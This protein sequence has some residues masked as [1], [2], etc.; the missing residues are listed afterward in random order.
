MSILSQRN[1]SFFDLLSSAQRLDP[2]GHAAIGLA[3]VLWA[4]TAV[5]QFAS[6]PN[7]RDLTARRRMA[8]RYDEARYV[9]PDVLQNHKKNVRTKQE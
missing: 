1:R 4:F 9:T 7:C 3:R 8:A 6:G 2:S 5:L